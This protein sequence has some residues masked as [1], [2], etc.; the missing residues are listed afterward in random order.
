[1][2]DTVGPA[3]RGGLAQNIDISAGNV[4]PPTEALSHRA[5]KIAARID[6]LLA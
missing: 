4:R 1:L 2:L 3:L 6:D 5:K